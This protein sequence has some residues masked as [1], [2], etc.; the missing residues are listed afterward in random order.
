MMGDQG[1]FVT[2]F[3]EAMVAGLTLDASEELATLAGL[4]KQ[5]AVD[6]ESPSFGNCLAALLDIRAAAGDSLSFSVE[7]TGLFSPRGPLPPIR[8][9]ADDSAE[10][11][12]DSSPHAKLPKSSDLP[13]FTG[14]SVKFFRTLSVEFAKCNI[15]CQI[16]TDDQSD[17]KAERFAYNS[18]RGTLQGAQMQ[19]LEKTHLTAF[20]LYAAMV[21]EVFPNNAATRLAARR[22]PGAI[23]APTSGTELQNLREYY[24]LYDEA[25]EY[26]QLLDKTFNIT[27]AGRHGALHG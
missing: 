1:A 16:S 5:H 17:A 27:G 24:R 13:K 20:D 18:L 8:G 12:S 14:K 10:H 22:A 21:P 3:Q 4:L 11:G 2:A 23:E 15:E 25:E 19:A 7:P 26:A 6:R 9:G